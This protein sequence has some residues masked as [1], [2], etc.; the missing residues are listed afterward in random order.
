MNQLLL[1]MPTKGVLRERLVDAVMAHH[2]QTGDICVLNYFP[3]SVTK[4]TQCVL[5]GGKFCWVTTGKIAIPDP[6]GRLAWIKA[7]HLK[8]QLVVNVTSSVD[9]LVNLIDFLNG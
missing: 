3:G 4:H 6:S 1:P 2:E 7:D 9:V 8:P 5:Y